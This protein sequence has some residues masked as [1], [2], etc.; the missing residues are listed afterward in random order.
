MQ[1]YCKL[2]LIKVTDDIY[3]ISNVYVPGLTTALITDEGSGRC[4]CARCC[5]TS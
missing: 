4:A 5:R 3:V 1:W 2:K